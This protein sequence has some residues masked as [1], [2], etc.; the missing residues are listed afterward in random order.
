MK[1]IVRGGV[2]GL[3]A[4]ALTGCSAEVG[5]GG[6]LEEVGAIQQ[7]V[8]LTWRADGL[9]SHTVGMAINNKET[10]FMW[11]DYVTG[12]GKALGCSGA[13]NNPCAAGPTFQYVSGFVPSRIRGI[14]ISAT[15]GSVYAW[16]STPG[17][18]GGA[19]FSKG[20]K[21]NLGPI[22]PFLTPAGV[23]I[24]Q[25]IEVEGSG[26]GTW[27]FWW[28]VNGV[29]K[30]SLSNTPGSAGSMV[31]GNVQVL[32]KPIAGIAIQ[33]NINP[34]LVYTYYGS[35]EVEAPLNLSTNAMDLA[36]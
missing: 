16:G 22:Q 2:L 27:Q 1:A 19:S 24:D 28:N 26:S 11:L 25:L 33:T 7:S 12:D 10:H 4:L 17:V 5:E 23:T 21:E 32:S 13:F 15:N 36:H 34:N 20:T 18:N 3:V 6:E 14:G 30:R 8:A 9:A 29:V 31:A 35:N